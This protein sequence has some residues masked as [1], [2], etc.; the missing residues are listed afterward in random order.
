MC[1]LWLSGLYFPSRVKQTLEISITLLALGRTIEPHDPA[2][3][4]WRA[5]SKGREFAVGI[6][7]QNDSDKP[8]SRETFLLAWN[9][10]RFA[11]TTLD[12]QIRAV[13]AHGSADDRHS[14]GGVKSIPVGSRFFMIRLG[15]E[16]RGLIAAGRTISD[17][18]EGPHWDADRA[19]Q[20][21][22]ANF[23]NIRFDTLSRE[24]LIRRIELD[25]PP[26]DR[27]RAKK[28]DQIEQAGY[29]GRSR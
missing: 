17:V 5:T 26:F 4:G 20:G 9:P 27:R 25:S 22:M 8:N 6:L 16:P 14:C 1:T 28:L 23:V 18:L 24:P 15:I 11:W 29:A 13:S 3:R 12:E 19:A 10:K 2:R 7:E 21:D